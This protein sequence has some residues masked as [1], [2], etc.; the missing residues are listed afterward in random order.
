MTDS[1]AAVPRIVARINAI[2]QAANPKRRFPIEQK[3]LT[4]EIIQA[5]PK[6]YDQDGKGMDATVYVKFFGSGRTTWY[7]TEASPVYEDGVQGDVYLRDV[8]D[9]QAITD[10]H[11]FGFCVSPLGADCDELGYVSLVELAALEFPPFGL[12]IERDIHFGERVLREALDTS[13]LGVRA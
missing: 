7:C 13:G 6:L 4:A 8:S 2:V 11:F 3:L 9:E 1:L 10:V 12:P 5:I